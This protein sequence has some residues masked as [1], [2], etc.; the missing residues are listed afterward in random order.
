MSKGMQEAVS[1]KMVKVERQ[2]LSIKD[3]D[4]SEW[5]YTID[6]L[7]AVTREIKFCRGDDGHHDHAVRVLEWIAEI[8]R[9]REEG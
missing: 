2:V 9:Q 3:S 7:E 1:G 5:E 8:M 6:H 4:G